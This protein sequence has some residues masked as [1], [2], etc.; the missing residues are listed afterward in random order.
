MPNMA[1]I[2]TNTMHLF[3]LNVYVLWTNKLEIFLAHFFGPK[4]Y[5]VQINAFSTLFNEESTLGIVGW[6][7]TPDGEQLIVPCDLCLRQ[8]IMFMMVLAIA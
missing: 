8:F 7:D 5:C 2:A 4:T 1:L 3:S 6:S